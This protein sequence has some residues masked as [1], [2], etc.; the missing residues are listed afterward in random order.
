[1]HGVCFPHEC[2]A[3]A[4]SPFAAHSFTPRQRTVLATLPDGAAGAGWLPAHANSPA[5]AVAIIA[6]RTVVLII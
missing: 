1:L 5:A 6:P 3:V 2:V 4:H